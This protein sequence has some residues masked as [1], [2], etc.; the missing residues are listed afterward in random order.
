MTFRGQSLE[1]WKM[2]M[3]IMGLVVYNVAWEEAYLR[4][5]WHLDPSSHLAAIDM[6]RKLE[7]VP[8]LGELG[9]HLTQ[10]RLGWELPPYQVVSWRIQ[11]FDHN[12]HG[13][14]IGGLCPFWG[15]ELGSHLTQCG[16]GRGLPWCQVSSWS[17]Q[18]FGHN[19]PK[20]QT[21][22]QTGHTM[23]WQPSANHYT[24]SRR[25]I[26]YNKN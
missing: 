20:S 21:D 19:T 10:C 5:K 7:A 24:N 3:K 18:R 26:Y 8:P 9:P 23:V 12:E 15:E 14:K 13:P 17:I 1:S 22:R 16:R 4:T 11:P 2:A 25:N 6:G